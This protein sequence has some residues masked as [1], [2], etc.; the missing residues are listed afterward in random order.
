MTQEEWNEF[1]TDSWPWVSK[2]VRDTARGKI[3]FTEDELHDIEVE[4]MTKAFPSYEKF[5]DQYATGSRNLLHKI[6][7]NLVLKKVRQAYKN[8]KSEK[9]A[10][11]DLAVKA[12]EACAEDIGD[13]EALDAY[14]YALFLLEQEGLLEYHHYVNINGLTI[15]ETAAKMNVHERT[16]KRKLKL[17]KEIIT[18]EIEK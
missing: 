6:A 18:R 13:F 7:V 8:R 17:S 9:D 1:I 12:L 16:V 4:V 2:V 10:M 3:D 11:R 5:D 15:A 14:R